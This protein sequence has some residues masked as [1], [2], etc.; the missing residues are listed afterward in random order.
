[1]TR[2]TSVCPRAPPVRWT[3]EAE[4]VRRLAAAMSETQE[5][6]AFQADEKAAPMPGSTRG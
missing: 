5:G 6:G 2:I 1:M 3:P 4:P